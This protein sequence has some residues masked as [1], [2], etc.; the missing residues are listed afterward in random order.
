[1]LRT[2]FTESF[3]VRHPIASAGMAFVATTP[4][5]NIVVDEQYADGMLPTTRGQIC[6]GNG[7]NGARFSQACRNC[8]TTTNVAS[9]E[10]CV[11]MTVN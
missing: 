9:R 7:I 3:G 8:C 2:R 6:T 11:V 10:R 5:T 1:M 4:L